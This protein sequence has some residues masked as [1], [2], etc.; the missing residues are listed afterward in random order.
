MSQVVSS[1]GGL[2]GRRKWLLL[3]ASLGSV[4]AGWG[5]LGARVPFCTR[6]STNSKHYQMAIVA[7]RKEWQ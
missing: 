6:F 3:N 5:R 4:P 2:D 7:H 1:M